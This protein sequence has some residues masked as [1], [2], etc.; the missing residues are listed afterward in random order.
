MLTTLGYVDQEGIIKNADFQR[1][2]FRNNADVKFNDKLSMKLDLSFS[3]DD[4]KASPYQLSLI[5]ILT[6]AAR[7]P[8][9]H[10]IKLFFIGSS[11][12]ASAAAGG[13]RPATGSPGLNII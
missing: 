6:Q 1:Y 12:K 10:S 4:R 9:R 5:H 3:N 13:I 8:A 2:T 11:L 7:Q